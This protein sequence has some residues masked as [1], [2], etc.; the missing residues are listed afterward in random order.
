MGMSENYEPNKVPPRTHINS[1]ALTCIGIPLE[2]HNTRLSDFREDGGKIKQFISQYLHTLTTKERH[3]PQKG[4]FFFGS[5]GVGKTMLSCIILRVAYIYRYTCRR[6]TFARYVSSYTS[7]WSS[8]DEPDL[9]WEECK[10]S[11]YLVLEE[12]GK[13]IDSKVT[14]PILEELLRYREEHGLT[15]IMCT[16]L[17]PSNLSDI[18]GASIMSLIKGG[19]TPIKITGVDNRYN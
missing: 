14:K 16:N 12:V 2:F 11:K 9:L 6:V 8:G 13:E 7:T 4:V 18:Y 3:E 19:M 17:T 5:N 10:G 15:T 1:V